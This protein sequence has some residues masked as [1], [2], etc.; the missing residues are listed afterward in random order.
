M[1]QPQISEVQNMDKELEE[2]KMMLGVETESKSRPVGKSDS[3]G[4]ISQTAAGAIARWKCKICSHFA[5]K[6]SDMIRHFGSTHSEDLMKQKG[7]GYKG[8]NLIQQGLI[9]REY[10]CYLCDYVSKEKN[11]LNLHGNEVHGIEGENV[12]Y[13]CGRAFQH[14]S[15]LVA[16][17]KGTNIYI[18]DIHKIFGFFDP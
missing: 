10:K 12:C 9:T 2:W 17:I 3:G 14:K 13:E 5:S 18:Y 7:P 1:V 4:R 11:Q 15:S 8:A 16:H 6:R